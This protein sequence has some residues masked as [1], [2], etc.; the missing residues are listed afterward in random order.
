MSTQVYPESARELKKLLQAVGA[1]QV[2][3]EY[4]G[5]NDEG[6]VNPI[7]LVFPDGKEEEIKHDEGGDWVTKDGQWE[8]IARAPAPG[9]A[10]KGRIAE[11]IVEPVYDRY[12][13]FA[14]DFSCHGTVNFAIDDDA[15]TVEGSES[16]EVWSSVW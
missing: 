7:T 15:I 14:G 16:Q 8:F 1:I 13:S 5:G 11:L 10:E 12:G 2:R 9:D 6:Y 3:A 4:F